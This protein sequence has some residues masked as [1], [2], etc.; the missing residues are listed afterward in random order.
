[1]EN[2]LSPHDSR[3]KTNCLKEFSHGILTTR[4]KEKHHLTLKMT[5]T[6][7]DET[8]V[9]NNSSTDSELPSP[10]RSHYTNYE[11]TPKT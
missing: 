4:K 10:G 3:N 9:T 6:Q 11:K 7:V 1:M 2:S 5:S 8:P